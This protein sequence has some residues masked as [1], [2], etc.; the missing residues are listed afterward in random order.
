MQLLLASTTS[1]TPIEMA[2]TTLA[3]SAPQQA[4]TV[5][6]FDYQ[7]EIK[8]IMHDIETKL[9]AKLEA[10]IANLQALV[11]Q[12]EQ[13]FEQKLTLQIESL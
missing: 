10:A 1:G 11:E 4:A 9:K 5:Q 7:V 6:P 13:K 2:T 3:Q 12:L 8:C